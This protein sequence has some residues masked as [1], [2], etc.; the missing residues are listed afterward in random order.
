MFDRSVTGKEAASHI[1]RL[2]HGESSVTEFSI[3]FQT[4]AVLCGWNE[5]ALW[6]VFSEG[7]NPDIQEEI[8]IPSQ[9]TSFDDLLD[10]TLRVETHINLHCQRVMAHSSWPIPPR[11]VSESAT[12]RPEPLLELEPMQVGRTRLAAEDKQRHLNQRLC[13]YCEKNLGILLQHVL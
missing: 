3:Q 10:L 6:D 5:A 7:L 1:V 8:T 4:L 13:F 11:S 9:H 12:V 2:R